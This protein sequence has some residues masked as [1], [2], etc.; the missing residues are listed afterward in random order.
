MTRN[1]SVEYQNKLFVFGGYRQRRQVS[2]VEECKL[3]RKF[4]LL[5]D[6][7]NGVC[8]TF[9]FDQEPE[10]VLLCFSD[11]S[12]KM[13][14]RYDGNDFQQLE[15]STQYNH[16]YAANSLGKYNQ[17]ALVVGGWN[18]AVELLEFE[19]GSYKWNLKQSYPFH[20]RIRGAALISIKNY[21]I[22]F[23]GHGDHVLLT[24]AQ[25]KDDAWTKIGDLNQSRHAHNCILFG[26]EVLVVGGWGSL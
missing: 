19:N 21:V 7:Y 8:G 6:F 24:V 14:H 25:F 11:S 13:C 17:G 18:K 16:Q 3:E 26:S 15:V 12:D 9:N 2:I 23:G 22:V 20:S 10:V 4:D 5:F 1:E